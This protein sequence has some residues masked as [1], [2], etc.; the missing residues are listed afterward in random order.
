M[1]VNDREASFSVITMNVSNHLW[2]SALSGAGMEPDDVC[3]C[4]AMATNRA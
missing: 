1:S 4:V 3:Q 2:F